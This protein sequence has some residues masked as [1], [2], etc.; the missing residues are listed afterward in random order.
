MKCI[1]EFCSILNIEHSTV[2]ATFTQDFLA[3]KYDD[4]MNKRKE[5]FDIFNIRDRK[6]DKKKDIDSKIREIWV[7][8]SPILGEWNG[9]ILAKGERKQKRVK[10]KRIDVSEYFLAPPNCVD[11]IG[12]F[13]D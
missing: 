3:S 4:I 10:G 11:F 8:V 5:W 7:T 6:G 2:N 12:M 9:S 13:R 1:N